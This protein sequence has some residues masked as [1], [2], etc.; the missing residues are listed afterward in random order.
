MSIAKYPSLR[1]RKGLVLEAYMPRA[2]IGSG[3][4]MFVVLQV[5]RKYVHL[6]YA[7]RLMSIRIT[8]AQ[9]RDLH[10]QPVTTFSEAKFKAHV[11]ERAAQFERYSGQFNH[12]NVD[13]ILGMTLTCGLDWFRDNG[14]KPG[15]IALAPS[16]VR[17]G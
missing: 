16:K 12:G 4:R 15:L 5:G 14:W 6:F 1:P 3:L 2:D 11:R 9:W 7:P 10:M 17:R 13:R 8:L